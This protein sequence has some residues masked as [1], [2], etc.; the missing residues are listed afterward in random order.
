VKPSNVFHCTAEK[1]VVLYDFG[2]AKRV[3]DDPFSSRGVVAMGTPHYVSPEQLRRLPDLDVRADL[4]SLGCTWY[5]LL[6]GRP[7]FPGA[8]SAEIAARHLTD[9]F[10]D[11]S[12]VKG[13]SETLLATAGMLRKLCAKRREDRYPDP[14]AFLSDVD[15]LA[16]AFGRDSETSSTRIAR[17]LLERLIRPSPP[18]PADAAA[19]GG[20]QDLLQRIEEMQEENA[21]LFCERDLM[22]H[23]AVKDEATIEHLEAENA[24]LACSRDLLETEVRALRAAMDGLRLRREAQ[25]RGRSARQAESEGPSGA[26]AAPDAPNARE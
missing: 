12:A 5:H 14:K 26:P 20:V 6:T 9:P 25:R 13:K 3:T 23:E 19:Y 11:P 21:R 15:E 18:V 1:R 4:Y 17:S 10:P 24:R 8:S 16:E 2:L 7:P 22:R